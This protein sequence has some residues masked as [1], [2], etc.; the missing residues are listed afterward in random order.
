MT[1]SAALA[2]IGLSSGRWLLPW[3]AILLIS[4]TLAY[5]MTRAIAGGASASDQRAYRQAAVPTAEAAAAAPLE[6]SMTSLSATSADSGVSS[7]PE[8]CAA[9]GGQPMLEG[10]DWWIIAESRKLACQSAGP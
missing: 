4:A 1:R 2:R 3:I 7:I 8:P 5:A 9:I 10:V 6:Q